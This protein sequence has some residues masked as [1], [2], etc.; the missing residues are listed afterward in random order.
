M[1]IGQRVRAAHLS[2]HCPGGLGFPVA[3]SSALRAEPA[4]AHASQSWLI[5][6]D[7]AARVAGE[8]CARCARL[9]AP[10]QDARCRDSRDWVH[11]S[12]PPVIPPPA[13]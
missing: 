1:R 9:I 3:S 8:V 13:A 2:N 4:R 10:T 5:A 11:E 6:G 12:C 7:H